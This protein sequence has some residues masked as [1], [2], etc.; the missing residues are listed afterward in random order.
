MAS[1][2]YERGSVVMDTMQIL[3]QLVQFYGGISTLNVSYSVQLDPKWSNP[4]T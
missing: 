2:V 4:T 3:H 1:K